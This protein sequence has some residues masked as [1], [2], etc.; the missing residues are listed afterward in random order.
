VGIQIGGAAPGTGSNTPNAVTVTPGVNMVNTGNAFFDF[1]PNGSAVSATRDIVTL[2]SCSACHDGKVLAHGS[3]KDPNYCVTCHT[4][5]I[6][7]SFD[8]GNAPMT[9]SAVAPMTVDGFTFKVQTGSNAVVRPA[10]AILGGNAVGNFPN[11]VHKIHMGEE[12]VKQGYNFN[13]AAEGLFN[14]NGLPQAPNNCTKCHTG[15]APTSAF[16]ARQTV[17][18]NNWNQVPSQLACGACHDGI[19][20]S[21]DS[22]STLADKSTD[23]S[24]TATHPA[25][26]IGTTQSGHGRKGLA[27][28]AACNTCHEASTIAVS[29]RA[30]AP[31]PNNLTAKAGYANFSYAIKSVTVN[32]SGNPVVTFQIKKDGAVVTALA[33]PTLV[34]NG[35]NGQ[36]VV[37]GAYEPIPGFAG[38]PTIALPYGIS[39]DGI[40]KP[41][42]FNVRPSVSLTNLLI[43]SGSPKAGSLSNTVSAGAYQADA[44]GYFTATITGDTLG[45]PKGACAAPVA[46]AT[47]TCVI[48][49]VA[50]APIIIP[51]NAQMLTA[52][53]YGAFT[54]KGLSDYP[55]VAAVVTTNPTT[56]ASG[57][58]SR[59]PVLQQLVATGYTA[60]RA[61]VASDRCNSCHD[62]LGTSPSFH[63]QTFNGLAVEGT[64]PRNDATACAIC[65]TTNS[66]S[67]GWSYNSS[68]FIHGIHGASKRTVPYT[69]QSGQSY[70]TLGYPGVLKDCAQCHL[71]NTVNFGASGATLQPNLLATTTATGTTSAAGPST[72]P[73]IA[74][75]AGTKYGLAFSFTPQGQAVAS[76]TLV[77]GTVVTPATPAPVGGYT[78]QAEATTLINSP[79][80][81]ACFACHDTV[82]ATNHMLT[83]GGSIYGARGAQPVVSKEA[84]L[85]CH[86]AGSVQDAVVVHNTK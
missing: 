78:R 56:G 37:D 41:A 68:T 14:E 5:Q 7:F 28:T 16:T 1:V 86:G 36:K 54:Q 57:G 43:A 17:D 20:F 48:T 31:T 79:I 38:G 22:G 30:N 13:N 85:V 61:I 27:P 9:S 42:D 63:G 75:T 67:G 18:G 70:W 66:A 52:V 33:V 58:L 12:L 2:A 35:A 49:A 55:Y 50:A 73:Y 77:D 8:Q 6:K 53:L 10:Q 23:L 11:M 69:W 81:A 59:A 29:H 21:D 80:S 71:P 3:R 32:A 72:S 24:V 64:G 19:N 76:Y 45:Q 34:T 60:R 46:P 15:D 84:C 26:P 40:A 44:S 74:Q 65:H 47:A 39:Q 82:A 4:D 83:N 51:A 25:A 62:V